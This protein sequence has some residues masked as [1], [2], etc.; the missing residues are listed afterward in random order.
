MFCCALIAVVVA[1][2]LEGETKSEDVVSIV[3]SSQVFENDGSYKFRYLICQI[4]FSFFYNFPNTFY[5]ISSFETS[6]GVIREETGSIVNPGKEDAYVARVGQFR[7]KSP[8]GENV[9]IDYT[10]DIKGYIPSGRS[11]PV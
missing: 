1:A 10:A 11:V 9:Q 6:D 3:R 7:Y 8:D 4:N 5:L 2:P